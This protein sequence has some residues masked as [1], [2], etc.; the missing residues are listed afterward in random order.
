MWSIYVLA[1]IIET[2]RKFGSECW[3]TSRS[4]LSDSIWTNPLTWLPFYP[5]NR[6]SRYESI[7]NVST[8]WW[9][10]RDR[11]SYCRN[12]VFLLRMLLETETYRVCLFVIETMLQSLFEVVDSLHGLHHYHRWQH[13]YF[14]YLS[15]HH[16]CSRWYL[17]HMFMA[18]VTSIESLCF[19]ETRITSTWNSRRTW[20]ALNACPSNTSHQHGIY[21]ENKKNWIFFHNII[22]HS[23]FLFKG[24]IAG[25][26]AV[27]AAGYVVWDMG[28]VEGL[29]LPLGDIGV[30]E[31]A[32]LTSAGAGET[33]SDGVEVTCGRGCGGSGQGRGCGGFY[34]VLWLFF[35]WC[36]LRFLSF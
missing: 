15:R 28:A 4:T 16:S 25:L 8:I 23:C 34:Q 13:L 32:L 18:R 14:M 33:V 27:G 35:L 5:S 11:R 3:R 9:I 12:F 17:E 29:P 21:T 26:L 6:C 24:S 30:P 22:F 1:E 36:L 7:T 2:W 31:V 19:L 20:N 10:P